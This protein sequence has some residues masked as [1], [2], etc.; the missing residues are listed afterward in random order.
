MAKKSRATADNAC[1]G[2]AAAGDIEAIVAGTH[3]DPFAVLGVQQ[4][5][6]AFFARCF[7]PHAEFVT[8]FTLAG[9]KAG[10]LARSDD[11]GFFEGKLSIRKRQPLRYHARNEGASGG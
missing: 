3:G 7:I 8:A 6:K 11:A 4:A 5:G 2:L 1:E 10:E 9:R